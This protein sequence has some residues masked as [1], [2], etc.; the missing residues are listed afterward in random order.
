MEDEMTPAIA[1]L[2]CL[3]LPHSEVAEYSVSVIEVNEVWNMCSDPPTLGITQLI[4]RDAGE[5]RDWRMVKVASQLPTYSHERQI[6]EVTMVENGLVVVVKAPVMVE[7]KTETDPELDE[8][9]WLPECKR[10]RI[11][12]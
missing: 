9:S 2:L 11:N 7:S 5:I 8:R 10:C 4:F 3:T 1:M 6:W 12:R